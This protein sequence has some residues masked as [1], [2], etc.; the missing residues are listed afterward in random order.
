MSRYITFSALMKDFRLHENDKESLLEIIR[1]LKEK[2]NW[3]IATILD[4]G[5]LLFSEEQK[6][7]I[8]SEYQRN[9]Q[10]HK[11]FCIKSILNSIEEGMSDEQKYKV[12]FDWF[13]SKIKYDYSIL[14]N[15]RGALYAKE[16]SSRYRNII[17]KYIT[18]IEGYQNKSRLEMAE[19]LIELL[20][21]AGE[22][23]DLIKLKQ[24]EKACWENAESFQ[25]NAEGY[26][27][28][29][30]F[31]THY[32]VC[33]DFAKAYKAICDK[34]GLECEI[35]IGNIL[36][37]EVECGHAWNAIVVS[38]EV[39]FIDISGAIHSNDGTFIDTEPDDFFNVSFQQL[40]KVDNGKGRTMTSESNAK[41][42]S[43]QS[44]L[45]AQSYD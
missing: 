37:D 11:E 26:K 27:I 13:V 8:V 43:I 16:S 3:E 31:I 33:E 44:R 39:K 40:Q 5:E 36:S 7:Q 25:K 1:L 19:S 14:E 30:V 23:R 28:G 45:N 20:Q 2:N 42:K 10:R 24:K 38:G 32:G 21:R 35:I 22:N 29:D 15:V 34:I 12:I 4:T 9:E 17:R 6:A 41:I 18:K